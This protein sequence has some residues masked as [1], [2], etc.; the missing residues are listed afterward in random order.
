[1]KKNQ[2]NLEICL[3]KAEKRELRARV[4]SYIQKNGT[5]SPYTFERNFLPFVFMR[6][7]THFLS[8]FLLLGISGTSLSAAYS[9]PGD[10]L[11]PVK[12][13]QEDI[14]VRMTTTPEIKIQKQ[15]ARLEKRLKEANSLS[16]KGFVSKKSQLDLETQITIHTEEIQTTAKSIAEENPNLAKS[17]LSEISITLAEKQIEEL[18]RKESRLIDTIENTQTVSPEKIEPVLESLKNTTELLSKEKGVT[19]KIK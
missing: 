10:V 6:K 14:D 8:I 17:I 2:K 1:M 4:F 5:P 16:E 11:Y 13:A 15:T 9:L 7:M 19:Q 3:T 12:L 18:E